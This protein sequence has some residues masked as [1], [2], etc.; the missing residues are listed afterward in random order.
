MIDNRTDHRV[1]MRM[2]LRD[3]LI[4]PISLYDRLIVQI[5]LHDRAGQS[6]SS[7][8]LADYVDQPPQL[9]IREW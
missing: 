5:N 4:A 6:P 9:L 8:C 1:I 3:Q 7:P 2:S